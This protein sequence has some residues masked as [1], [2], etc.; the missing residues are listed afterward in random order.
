MEHSDLPP[1]PSDETVPSS[2][3]TSVDNHMVSRKKRFML[4]IFVVLLL[5]VSGGGT[6]Y[7]FYM[8]GNEETAYRVLENNENIEDYEAYLKKYPN[9]THTQEVRERL[10][11][12]RV[13]YAEWQNVSKSSYVKDFERFRDSYPNS[14]LVKQCELKIDSLDWVE[15]VQTNTLEA[16]ERYMTYHPDGRYLS[17]ASIALNTIQ[18]SKV[19]ESEVQLIAST[20]ERFFQ[21]YG[22][23][24][25][26]ALCTCIT[27]VMTKFLSKNNA[28]KAEV[29]DIVARTY[30]EHILNCSFVLNNDYLCSKIT[31]D[32][33]K[34]IYKVDFTVDQHI[35]RDN[36]GKTFG[37]YTAHAELTEQFKISSLT[38]SEISRKEAEIA[39]EER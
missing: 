15:A 23:N 32:D 20:L 24:D 27:P 22:N 8:Q 28:T 10:A 12:L 1:R 21:A 6:A 18:N 7:Y 9:G 2:P 36:K 37:S 30:S 19:S 38:L 39:E 13:M 31:T 3:E 33:D 25:E 16:V 29:V 11:A 14:V 35:A 5:V 17:E 4:W 34:T 26:A